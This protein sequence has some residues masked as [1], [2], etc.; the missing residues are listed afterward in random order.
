MLFQSFVSAAL[1][2]SA[3]FAQPIQQHQH[4]QHEKRAVTVYNTIIV[5]A[6][7]GAPEQTTA[8][9]DTQATQSASSESVSSEP[10]EEQ[11][12][13]PASSAAQS[14]DTSASASS[15]GSGSSSSSSGS[16]NFSAGAK[17]VTYSPYN[18]DNSCKS[19]SQ[20]K[21]DISKL[22]DYSLIRLYGTDCNQVEN[23]L[24][25]LSSGQ[26]VFLGIFDTSNIEQQVKNLA[27]D[28]KNHGGWDIVDTVSVGNELVNSGQA[29]PS[30]VKQY[31]NT[32]KSAL[33]AA[34][35]NGP[36]V[37]VDTFIAVI[38]NP[39]LCDASDYLAVNAHAFFDGH[40]KAQDAGK[41]L[42]QQIQRVSSACGNK[43]KVFVT[44]TGWPTRGDSNNVAVPSLQNQKDALE[45]IA[46]SCGNDATY[47]NAFNDLWKQPGSYNAEQYWGIIQE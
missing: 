36:V 27:Q 35:Y 19:A 6:T 28:V 39:D 8:P 42:L 30:Q 10:V 11:P 26:K 4:H 34:G 15:T 32:A 38:N 43:K 29:N 47:F 44:E 25:A 18:K 46:S 24:A 1:V 14:A 41:W 2:A 7:G 31:V 21:S 17:G 22:S 20:V 37:S 40:V 23:T 33:K 3:A 12:S 16:N 5:T 9:V 13:V 45:G